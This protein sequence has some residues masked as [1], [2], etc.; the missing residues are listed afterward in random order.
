MLRTKI[1]SGACD[2]VIDPE[3]AVDYPLQET[4]ASKND[5]GFMSASGDPMPNLGERVWVVKEASG[6]DSALQGGSLRIAGGL[7]F[8]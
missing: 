7:K 4:E 2:P 5:V 8:S 3:L 6:E 1:D